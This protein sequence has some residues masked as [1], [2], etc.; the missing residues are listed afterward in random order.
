MSEKNKLKVETASFQRWTLHSAHEVDD[1]ELRVL[2]H[3]VFGHDMPEEQ[4]KW[5]YHDTPLRG[6]VLRRAGKAVAFFGGMPRLF[7]YQGHTYIGVQNGDVMVLP[8]ERGVF[9]RRGALYHAAS[10][11]FSHHVGE[12]RPYIFAFGFPNSRHF[13]L[14]VKLGLYSPAGRMM[15]VCWTFISAQK[16][17]LYWKWYELNKNKI[18]S[19][20]KLW[21]KMQPDCSEFFTPVRDSQRWKH[22]YLHHPYQPYTL[23]ILRRRWIGGA[24]AA[25]VMREHASHC[26]WTDYVGPEAQID[27][28]VQVAREWAGTKS[29]RLTALIS[30]AVVEKFSDQAQAV[31]PTQIDIP[32]NA[33]DGHKYPM[34]WAGKFWFMGGD[35]DSL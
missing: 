2:F 34:P 5:K 6:T 4:W 17:Q 28:A 25:L 18:S 9:S 24:L 10:H 7:L 11:F 29:K 26:E 19:I 12:N 14:G 8:D 16:N 3:L 22:R 30:D 33:M 20:D 21:K 32:V 13:Q 27:N 1:N 15:E 35:S 23:L 31:H